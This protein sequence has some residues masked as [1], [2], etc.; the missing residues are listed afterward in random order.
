M[1]NA[2]QERRPVAIGDA[3]NENIACRFGRTYAVFLQPKSAVIGGR[4]M[5]SQ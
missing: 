3:L 4:Y 2:M 5:P 1:S